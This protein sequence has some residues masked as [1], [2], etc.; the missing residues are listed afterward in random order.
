M[1]IGIIGLANAGKTTV[2]NAL[3]G[4]EVETAGYSDLAAEPN[5]GVVKVPDPR[6]D[7]LA[8]IYNPK[9]ITYATVEY[10][11]YLGIVQGDPAQNRKVADLI[12]DVDAVVHVVRGF[13]D[14]TVP[15]PLE[16]VD[17]VR[18]AGT[19]ELELILS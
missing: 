13:E 15:H 11:D 3:A 7:S 4:Q 9:K 2:F 6:V 12:K 10:V 5:V 8:E 17:P 19:V 14:E 18:D 1:K 16:S